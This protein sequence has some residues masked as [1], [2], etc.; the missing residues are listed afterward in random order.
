MKIFHEDLRSPIT[1]KM[2]I[3]WGKPGS[4]R[5]VQIQNMLG[6]HVHGDELVV[7]YE[8]ELQRNI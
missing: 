6:N 5:E 7:H 1:I 8:Y 2:T 3:H 4:L